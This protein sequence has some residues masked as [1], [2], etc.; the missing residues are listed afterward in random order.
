MNKS[1][2]PPEPRF[3]IY[4]AINFLYVIP[5]YSLTGLKKTPG[6]GRIGTSIAFN[7]A[8][9]ITLKKLHSEESAGLINF[10]VITTNLA[11]LMAMVLFLDQFSPLMY[12]SVRCLGLTV[13]L[14]A[15]A[16][17]YQNP[18]ITT[19]KQSPDEDSA[20]IA[21]PIHNIGESQPQIF[22]S[23]LSKM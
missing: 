9:S 14:I 20:V 6:A 17:G 12:D 4:R 8:L 7:I 18:Q 10:K 21:K 5:A 23:A 13:H 16:K 1:T 11:C 19:I 2:Y 15:S 22:L 3:S